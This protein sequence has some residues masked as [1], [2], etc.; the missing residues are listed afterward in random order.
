VAAQFLA[1]A[2]AWLGSPTIK[3]RRLQ[4]AACVALAVGAV[5]WLATGWKAFSDESSLI[6]QV[7]RHYNGPRIR[8]VS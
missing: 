5:W 1:P 3:G 2:F 4:H 7:L 6:E 8:Y